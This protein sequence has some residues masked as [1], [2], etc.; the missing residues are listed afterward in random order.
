MEYCKEKLNFEGLKSL[1]ESIT[2]Q[3]WPQLLIASWDISYHIK[4]K[5]KCPSKT[6]G[7]IPPI[8]PIQNKSGS[9]YC[10]LQ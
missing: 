8:P 2:K 4:R 9:L 10:L 7:N 5:K 6:N 1:I 3:L